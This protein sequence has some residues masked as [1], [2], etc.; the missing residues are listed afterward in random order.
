[1]DSKGSLPCSQQLTTGPC[2]QPNIHKMSLRSILI[3]SPHPCLY[4]PSALFPSGF[5]AKMLYTFPIFC[6]YATWPTHFIL[7]EMKNSL[8]TV[9]MMRP[10]TTLFRNSLNQCSSVQQAKFHT[11]TKIK[12][13]LTAALQAFTEFNLCLISLWKKFWFAIPPKID[14]QNVKLCF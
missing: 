13:F 12:R 8:W 7:L 11:H 14:I 6:M 2:S 4:L 3:L 5:L 1:M 9:Q 10:L